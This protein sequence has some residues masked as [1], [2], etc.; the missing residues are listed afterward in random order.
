[1]CDQP[2]SLAP[3]Q[4]KSIVSQFHGVTKHEMVSAFIAN[5]LHAM[6]CIAV[7]DAIFTTG[8]LKQILYYVS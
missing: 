4:I 1:M 2:S 3:I 6:N 7:N 5:A 8:N